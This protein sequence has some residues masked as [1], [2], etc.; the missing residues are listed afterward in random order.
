MNP[1]KHKIVVVTREKNEEKFI[2]KTIRSVLRQT[3]PVILHI[4]CDDHSDD[5]SPNIV[6]S[7]PHD[8]VKLFFSNLKPALK[9]HG[10]RHHKLLQ[11]GIDVVTKLVPDWQYLLILDGDTWIPP[12]YC[13]TLIKEMEKDPTLVMAGAK[14]LKT[15]KRIESAPLTHVRCSNHI[16]RREFYNKAISRGFF[17]D[18][19]LKHNLRYDNIH[20]EI[21]LE[22]FAWSQNL[23]V[24]TFPIT[25]CE[26]RPTGLKLKNHYV[27][28]FNE[29]KL[30]M[31]L[32]TFLIS[33]RNPDFNLIKRIIGWMWAKLTRADRYLT[34]REI[35]MLQR[36]HIAY[37]FMRLSEILNRFFH[38]RNSYKG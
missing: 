16:I 28:G 12:F 21:S 38:L 22:R 31:P 37:K 29:Y 18:K 17:Y 26:G 9:Q 7:F 35:R 20:G 19:I 27:K 3:Y 15:P 6:K 5:N 32:L 33:L 11:Y 34:P 30:G 10:V 24:K 8:K 25:A 4:V 13:E 14:Y 2:A 1:V 23:N 36:R